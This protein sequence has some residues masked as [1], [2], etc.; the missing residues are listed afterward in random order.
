MGRDGRILLH[1]HAGC[2][3]EDIAEAMGLQVKDLFGE[4][5]PAD[6]L[7]A[8]T[9]PKKSAQAAYEAEYIYRNADGIPILKKVKMRQ[10]DGGK[11]FFWQH[12]DGSKWAKGRNGVDP[13]L[14][15]AVPFQALPN[16][17]YL[18]EG[19]KDVE[20]LNQLKFPA[21]SLP[22]GAKSKWHP[23]Y[24]DTLRGKN[25][26]IIQDNDTPGKDFAQMVAKSLHGYAKEIYVLDLA[27][28]WPEVPEH[29]DVSDLIA[30]FGQGAYE[31]LAALTGNA[32]AW[33]PAPDS[34]PVKPALIRACD[35]PY[36][37]PKW[38]IAPYF[39]IGKGNLIQGDPGAGKTAFMCAVAAHVTTG[40]DLMGISVEEPGDVLFLSVEDDLPVLRGRFEAN[41]GDLTKCHF[42]TNAAG[43]TFNSPEVEAAIQQIHA[44]MVVFDPFQAFLG[45]SVDM[46]RSN[47]TRP[48]M[49]KLF[50]MCERHGCACVI[51]AHM[52]KGNRDKSPV[53]RALGSVDIPASMRSILQL[54]RNPDD[55]DECVMVHVKSSNA[56]KGRSL[57]YTIGDRG[58]VH[59]KGFSPMTAEDLNIVAK[60]K[61]KGVP[62]EN[63][64]LVQVFNQLITDKPG[65]GFWSYSDLKSVGAQI[66]GFPPYAD[67]NDLRKKLDG[68]LARE[69]QA[70]DG[71][72]VTHSE[73]G[74]GN[75]RGIRIEQYKNP[76]G[77]QT[78]IPEG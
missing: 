66:L 47:E 13:P 74:K 60:R 15:S 63:E 21:V 70:N 34:K 30:Q 36:E 27:Q 73:K 14:Y 20:N 17:I 44:K 57:A 49:A 31:M 67:I 61:E 33:Q 59:W 38:L 75:V 54:T 7:P 3:T 6:M 43:L 78:K 56:P 32:A 62:Y 37:P 1:C 25:V 39:Q 29:G 77:Y 71:L 19:E 8:Y 51:I 24:T 16:Y 58:G 10:P 69:L 28:V 23:Q 41:G 5:T 64:P 53:N 65:G 76:Q 45:A 42:M 18:V 4:S 35:I 40:R 55:E 68:G 22:D 72:I 2:S 52:S 9:A 50:D 11:Y 12:W 46:F 48:E 26:A